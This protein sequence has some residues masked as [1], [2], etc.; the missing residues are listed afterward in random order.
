MIYS[1]P[2]FDGKAAE[3]VDHGR[4]ALVHTCRSRASYAA[5]ELRAAGRP[6][7]A[8]LEISARCN[9]RCQMCA[10]S[11]VPPRTRW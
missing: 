9:L 11:K 1:H 5:G 8:F 3:E 4:S 2:R 10:C 6:L 7:E